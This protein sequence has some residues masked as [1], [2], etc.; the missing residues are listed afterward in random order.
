M[1]LELR[2]DFR[3]AEIEITVTENGEVLAADRV[4][5]FG[6]ARDLD[7]QGNAA[8]LLVIRL[9]TS[10]TLVR[11]VVPGA[12]R[13]G[14]VLDIDANHAF[15]RE[16]DLVDWASADLGLPAVIESAPD[17]RERSAQDAASDH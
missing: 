1:A 16:F 12:I 3:G 8:Q 4:R 11:I 10:P 17:V 13:G 7:R 9:G 15:P 14:R 2:I 5:A 6:D